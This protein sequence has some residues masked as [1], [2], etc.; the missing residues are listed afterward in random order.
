[1]YRMRNINEMNMSS[2]RMSAGSAV[3]ITIREKGFAL[4]M[5]EEYDS[6]YFKL[7]KP[8]KRSSDYPRS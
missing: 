1:M 5:N 3:F 8:L 2:A 4:G 7:S 6:M